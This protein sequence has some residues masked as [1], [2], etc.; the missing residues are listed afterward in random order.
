[1]PAIGIE[2][3]RRGTVRSRGR[4]RVSLFFLAPPLRRICR[5]QVVHATPPTEPATRMWI[6]D[7]VSAVT[8]TLVPETDRKRS[9]RLMDHSASA[10]TVTSRRADPMSSKRLRRDLQLSQELV[11]KNRTSKFI[12]GALLLGAATAA[13]AQS[14]SRA[15]EFAAQFQQMQT[16]S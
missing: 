11:M 2:M 12:A 16:L 1:M 6:A 8:G 5:A 3:L 10:A 4:R 13:G 7:A 14:S 15:Q 9:R